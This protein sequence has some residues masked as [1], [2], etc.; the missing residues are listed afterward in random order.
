MS[1][2]TSTRNDCEN[3]DESAGRIEAYDTSRVFHFVDDVVIR[4]RGEG[5]DSRVD[6]RSRSRDG[7]GD[8]GVNA[9][10]VR[11][12]TEAFKAET[13]QGKVLINSPAPVAPFTLPRRASRRR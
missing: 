6:M 12:Y 4:V 10:R 7:L 9:K 13:E 2:T 1:A 8:S 11:A 3:V 5:T